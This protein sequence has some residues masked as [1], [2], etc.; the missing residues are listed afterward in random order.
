MSDGI[1]RIVFL[2]PPSL[3]ERIG[4]YH[5]TREFHREVQYREDF[6]NYC[7]W[8]RA[9]AERNRRELEKMRGDINIFGWFSRRRGR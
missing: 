7:Q 2:P 5:V 9:T 3:D 6:Q 8:Y 4:S 1:N